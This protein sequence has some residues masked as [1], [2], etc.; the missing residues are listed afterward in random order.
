[1]KNAIVDGR[2]VWPDSEFGCSQSM[3]VMIMV[4]LQDFKVSQ[5]RYSYSTHMDDNPCG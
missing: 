2:Y 3:P 4:S 5:Y 1:M